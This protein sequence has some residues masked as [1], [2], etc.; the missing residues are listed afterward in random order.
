MKQDFLSR[1][2]V[3]E[4][5]SDVRAPAIICYGWITKPM[6]DDFKGEKH[7]VVAREESDTSGF[8]RWCQWEERPGPA[9]AEDLD[10]TL[11]THWTR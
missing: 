4:A 3:L 5:A 10:G 2:R 8:Y 9:P 7:L 1:L 6:P 11:V